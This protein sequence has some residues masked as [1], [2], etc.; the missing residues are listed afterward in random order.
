MTEKLTG[1]QENFCQ[2]YVKCGNQHA[3]YKASYSWENSTRKTIDEKASRLMAQDKIKARVAELQERVAVKTGYTLE[4]VTGMLENA[5]EMADQGN[6][7]GAAVNASMAI[8]KLHGMIVEK[9]EDV[10]AAR[11]EREVDARIAQLVADAT[12]ARASE[13]IGRTG[14]DPEDHGIEPNVSGHG[15][16]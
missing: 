7:A 4:K 1:R 12:E 14:D 15:T 13:A 16:A 2:A 9:R 3:A 6:Q 11:T 5:Y 8:A 10:T